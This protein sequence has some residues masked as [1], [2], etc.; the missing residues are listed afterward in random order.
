MINQIKD[1]KKIPVNQVKVD[2]KEAQILSISENTARQ[3]LTP[4]EEGKAYANYLNF[5]LDSVGVQIPTHKNQDVQELSQQIGVGENVISRRIS[6]L[7]LPEDVQKLNIII[8][9]RNRI[10]FN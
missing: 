2:D 6:L 9:N 8:K 3:N 4:V 7:L 10:Y 5:N 1:G